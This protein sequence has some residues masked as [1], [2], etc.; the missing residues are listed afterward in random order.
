MNRDQQTIDLCHLIIIK[1]QVKAGPTDG[2]RIE[3]P[4][5]AL[6][7]RQKPLAKQRTKRFRIGGSDFDPK[8]SILHRGM[9]SKAAQGQ[10]SAYAAAKTRALGGYEESPKP[11]IYCGH[12]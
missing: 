6:L 7:K 1:V 9:D 4:L 2:R 11:S 10:A 3:R 12:V 8:L 5:I